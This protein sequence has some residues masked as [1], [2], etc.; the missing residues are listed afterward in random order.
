MKR[1]LLAV[2]LMV[3]STAAFCQMFDGTIDGAIPGTMGD[4][5]THFVKK[6]YKFVNCPECPPEIVF[7]EGKLVQPKGEKVNVLIYMEKDE[8]DY[9]Y[10]ISLYYP[11]EEQLY[12]QYDVHRKVFMNSFGKPTKSYVTKSKWEFPMYT[13]TIGMESKSVY[14]TL[15]VSK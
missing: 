3:V 6:G 7:M 14:H 11:K 5:G 10:S 13:Y 4:V 12:F 1:L 15:K 8:D 9:V 2:V